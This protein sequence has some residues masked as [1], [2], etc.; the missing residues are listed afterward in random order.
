MPSSVEF[1]GRFLPVL[2]T[3]P[4]VDEEGSPR[5]VSLDC[6]YAPA[7]SILHE[8]Y[9]EDAVSIGSVEG[10]ELWVLNPVDLALSKLTRWQ[11]HDRR[12]VRLLA[13]QGWVT[14]TALER[15]AHE[16]AAGAIGNVAAFFA[17]LAE[18]LAMIRQ[19]E[20]PGGNG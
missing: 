5:S 2:L 18:A 6:N 19:C 12:D 15:R 14:A 4:Y 10:L 17:N 7:F 9:Q 20:L 8:D 16:A 11:D 13:E 1:G 3:I